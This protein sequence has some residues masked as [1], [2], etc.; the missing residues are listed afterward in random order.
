[1][2][3]LLVLNTIK[4]AGTLEEKPQHCSEM[5][6][7]AENMTLLVKAE[8]PSKVGVLKFTSNFL[9]IF[10]ASDVCCSFQIYPRLMCLKAF[11]SY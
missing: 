8:D 9:G 10:F 1:M 5:T 7:Q 4:P 6:L 2:S 3:R 11:A